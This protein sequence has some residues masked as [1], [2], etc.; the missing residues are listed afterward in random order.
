MDGLFTNLTS[1]VKKAL[2]NATKLVADE[3]D[4]EPQHEEVKQEQIEFAEGSDAKP[5]A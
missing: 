3:Q 5:T 4:D 2:E 1:G